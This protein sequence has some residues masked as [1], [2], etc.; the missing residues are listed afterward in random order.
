M[1]GGTWYAMNLLEIYYKH[2][3]YGKDIGTYTYNTDTYELNYVTDD[4]ARGDL[5]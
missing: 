5:G 3:S 1:F 4:V 2:W